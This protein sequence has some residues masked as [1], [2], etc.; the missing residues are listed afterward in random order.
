MAD[1]QIG[2][3][4]VI[5]LFVLMLLRVHIAVALGIVGVL[6]IA[7]ITNIDS[8][9]V[10]LANT[11]F[12]QSS[13]YLM[14][15]IPV[16]Q[17]M[18]E[19]AYVSGITGDA[20]KTAEKWVGHLPGG[21][22]MATTTACAAFA[23]VCGSSTAGATVMVPVSLPEMR[24]RKYDPG[25][26][27][28]SIASGGTL[29]ILIPPSA[30]FILY[31]LITEQSIGALF[32][33]GILPGIL[34]TAL[35]IVLTYIWTKR[36]P[37]IGPKG[38]EFSWRERL[39]S[40]GNL[41]PVLILFVVVMGG[42][43]AGIV[44]VNEAAGVGVFAALV[45]ALARKRLTKTN[46]VESL[47]S[48]LRAT[49]MIFA[50]II[51]AMVFNYFLAVSGITI[52]L[53]DF[54]TSLPVPPLA[55]IA[56]ILLMYLVLGCLMDAFAMLLIVVPIVF[57]IITALGFDPLWFGVISVVMIEVGLITPPVGI[58]VFI[59]SGMAKDVPM[60]KIFRGITPFVM[61]ALICVAIL[62]AFPQI[63]LLI[64]YAAK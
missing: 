37:E 7:I 6:G 58:N 19:L 26:A 41:W 27:L 21:L 23:A 1:W 24:K 8:A 32:L 34:L 16:F 50:L 49:G 59:I 33:S 5:L 15:V 25:F 56:A 39:F 42:I 10:K 48:T 40:L 43:Y 3:L 18:G 12:S 54:I 52:L 17:L 31:G 60:T 51:G 47:M 44:T 63:S 11:A 14:S 45:I 38:A 2:V 20:Y 29:A 4:G 13:L 46:M 28:G 62:V 30:A 53:S 35:F 55:I 9:L 64:P 57:P 22:S 36:N 61:A